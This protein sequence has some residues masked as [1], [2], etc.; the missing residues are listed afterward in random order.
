MGVV[1]LSHGFQPDYE[2]GF[3]N[4]LAKNGV[5]VTLIGSDRT[6]YERLQSGVLAINLRGSQDRGRAAWKKVLNLGIYIFRLM[7]FLVLKRPVLHLTGLF[8]TGYEK[9]WVYEC[10][11]Y[12]L[13][14]RRLVMT[15]HNVLPHDRDT[16]EMREVFRQ[17]YGIPHC[18]IVHTA[19]ARQRLISEFNVEPGR[20][21]V[22][23]HGLDDLV[24]V[25][26]EAIQA[27]REQLHVGNFDRLVIFFGAVM[28]YKGVDLLVEAARHFSNGTRVHI[29]GRCAD[30]K[31]QKELEALLHD[32]PLGQAI[33]WQ[34]SYLS[35]EHVSHLLGAADVL[36]MPYRHID[37]SG[38]LFAAMRHGTPIVAFDVGSF[39]DYLPD[40][41][42]LV[43]PAGDLPALA[44]AIA[45]IPSSRQLR[46]EIHKVAEGFLWQK[47]VRPVLE[48]YEG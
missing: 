35:E 3:A 2:A 17:V 46:P 20:I 16:P 23:E 29:A 22:M 27:T 19:K 15:V 11:T 21:V 1:L 31:Y 9:S 33:T 45:E 30:S 32:H 42:G 5:P 24:H 12:R 40:G 43:V 25:S 13:L 37:Q 4:G 36:V 39:H 18:L 34:N 38:V 26:A 8:L 28:R 47:T 41:V 48:C 7:S 44:A 14:S 10:R 6:L